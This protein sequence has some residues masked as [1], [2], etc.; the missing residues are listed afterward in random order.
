VLALVAHHLKPGVLYDERERVS[1]GAIRRLAR[2]C[3]PDLLYR[4]ARADCLGRRPGVFEAVAME[5]FRER[6][7]ALDVAVR[8]PE[9]LLR[10]R[11]LLELGLRPGPE[12]GRV[13][14][15][16]Y[17]RQLDGAV[18]TLGEARDE[19]RR[20]LSADLEPR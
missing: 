17:E 8:P 1:D 7:R 14:Q 5:W 18:T 11:D 3:E 2:K 16:V 10:G 13:L 6:V 15:A 20:I 4:V 9:P 12:V 19:A